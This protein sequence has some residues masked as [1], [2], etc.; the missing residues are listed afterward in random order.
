MNGQTLENNIGLAAK[1]VGNLRAIIQNEFE[2]GNTPSEDDI[3]LFISDAQA[4]IEHLD[5]EV[6]QLEDWVLNVKK[7][8]KE[9]RKG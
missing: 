9:L 2:G 3:T 6:R 1:R 5:Q 8:L 4:G 7:Y